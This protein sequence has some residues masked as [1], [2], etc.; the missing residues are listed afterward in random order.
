MSFL[1]IYII[2]VMLIYGEKK[3]LN[4]HLQVGVA[5]LAL[6]EAV[7]VVLLPPAGLVVVILISQSRNMP[8]NEPQNGSK[9]T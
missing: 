9:S 7:S 5:A 4:I 8:T 2:L 6:N 3:E 1:A